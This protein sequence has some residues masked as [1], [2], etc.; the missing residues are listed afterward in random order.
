MAIK[1]RD[2]AQMIINLFAGLFRAG[3][4]RMYEASKTTSLRVFA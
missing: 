4:D 1:G 2:A 3:T